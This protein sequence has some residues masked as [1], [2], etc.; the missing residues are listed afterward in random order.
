MDWAHVPA[1]RAFFLMQWHDTSHRF[2]AYCPAVRRSRLRAAQ[3]W[4]NIENNKDNIKIMRKVVVVQLHILT[5][6]DKASSPVDYEASLAPKDTHLTVIA[7]CIGRELAS[8]SFCKLGCK[9]LT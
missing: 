7:Q 6:L 5:W 2:D 9:P 8:A 1:M 3:S 4:S